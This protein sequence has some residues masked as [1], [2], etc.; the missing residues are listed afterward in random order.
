MHVN[1]ISNGNAGKN[2]NLNSGLCLNSERETLQATEW[3]DCKKQ[4]RIEDFTNFLTM[5]YLVPVF[6]KTS[7]KQRPKDCKLCH[8]Q[9]TIL[10]IFRE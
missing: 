1:N 2:V 9:E 5:V 10:S 6:W 8:L 4:T 3:T 7:N